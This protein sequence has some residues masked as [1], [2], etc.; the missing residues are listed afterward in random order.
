MRLKYVE[1]VSTIRIH[2]N[3]YNSAREIVRRRCVEVHNRLK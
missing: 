1:Q 2:N 3:N